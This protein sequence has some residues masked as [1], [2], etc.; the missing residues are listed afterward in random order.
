MIQTTKKHFKTGYKVNG[1]N[2]KSFSIRLFNYAIIF[3]WGSI[4]G[5]KVPLYFETYHLN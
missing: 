5:N 2:F 3:Y 1:A 4:L